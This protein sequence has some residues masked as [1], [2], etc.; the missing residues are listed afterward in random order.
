[1]QDES[2][3]NEFSSD[4]DDEETNLLSRSIPWD[5][6]KTKPAEVED[7]KLNTSII[8][9]YSIK[10]PENIYGRNINSFSFEQK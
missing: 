7:A 2:D 3:S 8:K 10:N 4:S 6:S 9:R 1:M 5:I